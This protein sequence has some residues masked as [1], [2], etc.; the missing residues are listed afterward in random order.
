MP[1]P[2][3]PRGHTQVRRSEDAGINVRCVFR[4]V[5]YHEWAAVTVTAMETQNRAFP[6]PQELHLFLNP[7]T[8]FCG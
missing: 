7:E 1:S 3:L 4:S 6:P 8:L 2:R 5:P